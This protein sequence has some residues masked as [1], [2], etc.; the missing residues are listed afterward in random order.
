[1]PG[2]GAAAVLGAGLGSISSTVTV[3]PSAIA[4]TG[5]VTTTAPYGVNGEME[6]P[7]RLTS[8]LTTLRSFSITTT[9]TSGSDTSAY[10]GSVARTYMHPTKP[11]L[12]SGAAFSAIRIE[13]ITERCVDT[14]M[15]F[16]CL[17]RREAYGEGEDGAM[18]H[19]LQY[20]IIAP[21]QHDREGFTVVGSIEQHRARLHIQLHIRKQQ[22]LPA[23]TQP[24][25]AA[26]D[27]YAHR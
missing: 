20:R 27:T 7:Q 14:Q 1:V 21:P 2:L 15:A 17:G 6:S 23:H 12:V 22:H 3:V 24:Y 4:L 16:G 8:L 19:V 13:Q 5:M 9:R 10:I 26:S 11:R 18:L 25:P